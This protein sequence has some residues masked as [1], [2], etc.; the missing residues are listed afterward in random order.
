[1]FRTRRRFVRR[2]PIRRRFVLRRKRVPRSYR[3]NGIR[4]FKFTYNADVVNT[5]TTQIQDLV[6]SGGAAGGQFTA[7][8]ALFNEYRVNGI[9]IRYVPR[10]NVAPTNVTQ[11]YAPILLFHDWNLS[12]THTRDQMQNFEATKYM[13]P[14]R[15]WTYFRKARRIFSARSVATALQNTT[16]GWLTTNTPTATQRILYNAQ[17]NGV[18]PVGTFIITLYVGFRQRI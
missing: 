10:F 17:N 4:F 13:D 11:S 6:P 12:G 18:N 8:C 16:S 9:K 1:M 7:A 3:N 15:T 14:F 2:R 5:T